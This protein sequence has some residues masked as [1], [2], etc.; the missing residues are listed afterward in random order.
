MRPGPKST[1]VI[2]CHD[3][4]II[5]ILKVDDIILDGLV[6]KSLY[7]Y[8]DIPNIGPSTQWVYSGIVTTQT[9]T[10]AHKYVL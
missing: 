1:I 4:T 5:T 9:R 7:L 10:H 6:K 8:I 3:K 2:Q